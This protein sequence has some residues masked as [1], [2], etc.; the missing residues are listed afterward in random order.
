MTTDPFPPNSRTSKQGQTPPPQEKKIEAV[1]ENVQ[2]RKQPLG[3]KVKQTF[4]SG[5]GKTAANH[6]FNSV[7]IP[8]AKETVVNMG[9]D[10]LERIVYGDSR[11]RS[12]S[13]IQSM[14]SHATGQVRYDKVNRPGAAPS[15]LSPRGR[16]S[17]NFDEIVL[18]NRGTAE[19]VLDRLKDIVDQFDQASIADL[20]SL[21]GERPDHTDHKWGWTDLR[22]TRVLPIRGGGYVIDL[23]RPEPLP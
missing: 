22:G 5:D 20:Y 3:K 9:R 7:L 10:F 21:V 4:F 12:T 14:M 1:T 17:H 19:E 2:R 13:P 8:A 16:A 18:D 23:P 11:P 6:V 15:G